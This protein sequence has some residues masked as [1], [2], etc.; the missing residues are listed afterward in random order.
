MAC[1]I[2]KLENGFRAIVCTRG[3]RSSP[4]CSC[5]RR[6]DFV[7]DWKIRPAMTC[8]APVCAECAVSPA[9]DKHICPE[10]AGPLRAWQAKRRG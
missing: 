7:C 6:A 9:K 5:G 3:R 1:E 4:K 8:D 2:V 10:R